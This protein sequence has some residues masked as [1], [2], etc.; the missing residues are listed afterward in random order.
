MAVVV[1]R[2][3]ITALERHG[4]HLRFFLSGTILT[5]I[6]PCVSVGRHVVH[7]RF[8]IHSRNQEMKAMLQ[9]ML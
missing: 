4:T 7:L 6:L 8:V 2:L 5:L 3:R 9:N 1:S